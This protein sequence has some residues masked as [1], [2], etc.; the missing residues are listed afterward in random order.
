MDERDPLQMGECDSPVQAA[1]AIRCNRSI[2]IF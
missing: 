1:I 2:V